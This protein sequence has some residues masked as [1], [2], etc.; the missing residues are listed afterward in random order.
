M[1]R[2]IGSIRDRRQRR[3]RAR[4]EA[5]GH[6]APHGRHRRPAR[7]YGLGIASA[8]TAALTGATYDIDGGQQFVS[9]S[10]H[11]TE[12][13]R[14]S[15]SPT[16]A[17]RCE[18]A[19]Q[20]RRASCS[21]NPRGGATAAAAEHVEGRPSSRVTTVTGYGDGPVGGSSI[22]RTPAFGAGCCRFEPCPPS[23]RCDGAG[24][25]RAPG[26]SCAGTTRW[27]TRFDGLPRT[28]AARERRAQ[29][30]RLAKLAQVDH[31]RFAFAPRHRQA[32][33]D[34]QRGRPDYSGPHLFDIRVIE[35]EPDP[36]TFGLGWG[37]AWMA[38]TSGGSM[39]H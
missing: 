38:S 20:G 18:R 2:R 6:A 24:T 10:T 3:H 8:A 28:P 31:G 13:T 25:G 37:T 35:R 22:G 12:R 27:P 5:W 34:Q 32:P 23:K 29:A 4:D 36:P 15:R 19:G 33:Q 11:D 14:V 39:H 9:S 21:T 7:R 26:W 30:E 17:L 1:P 16:A